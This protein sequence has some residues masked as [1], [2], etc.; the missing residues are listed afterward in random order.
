[1]IGK[2]F[3]CDTMTE[4]VPGKHLCPTC[5]A[6]REGSCTSAQVTRFR[7]QIDES[8]RA[9]LAERDAEYAKGGR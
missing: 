5:A 6:I 3:R 2:C 9:R 1:M 7:R 4:L 8:R